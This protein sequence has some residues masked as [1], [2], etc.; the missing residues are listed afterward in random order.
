MTSTPNP[1][2]SSSAPVTVI[3]LAALLVSLAGLLFASAP[4]FAVYSRPSLA[5]ITDTHGLLGEEVPLRGVGGI[6]I[7]GSEN[8][9][10]GV[11]E[12]EDQSVSKFNS[13][14]VF[15]E[16]LTG[17][18]GVGSLAVEDSTDRLYGVGRN[19][20]VAVDNSTDV[21]Y[22]ARSGGALAAFNAKEEPV[23]FAENKKVSYITN[24]ELIGVPCGESGSELCEFTKE[25]ETFAGVVVDPKNG[26]IYVAATIRRAIP[27]IVYEF[28]PSGRFV[29]GFEPGERVP[30]GYLGSGEISRLSGVAVDPTNDDLL[31]GIDEHTASAIDEFTSTGVFR[32]QITGPGPGEFFGQNAFSGG[33]AVSPAGVLYVGDGQRDRVDRWGHGAY[34]PTVVTGGVSGQGVEGV[35][36]A[37]VTLNGVVAGAANNENKDLVLSECE[38]EYVS[39]EAYQKSVSEGKSGFSALTPEE[40]VPCLL[41]SGA[42]PVGSRPE[43]KNYLVHAD[44]SGLESGTVYRYRL[45]AATNEAEDGTGQEGVAESFAAPAMPLVQSA[46]VGEVTSSWADFHAVIDPMGEDTSYQVQYVPASAYEPS[47]ADPYGAGGV[48]PLSPADIGSGDTGVDVGVQAGG[49][50]SGT[51]YHYRVVASNGAG[52]SDGL[53][54]TFSTVPAGLQGLPDG[55]AYE[56][57]TPA[58][59]GDAED[60]FGQI[61]FA[62]GEEENHDDG[63]ASEDGDHFLLVTG[64]SFGPFPA[65]GQGAYVFSRSK[66]GWSF[67]SVAS[68]SL[69]SQTMASLVFDPSDLSMV[70]VEVLATTPQGSQPVD[71]AGP[72][73]GPYVTVAAG[74]LA[75]SI[76]GGTPIKLMGA[77]EDLN[78][79]VVEGTDH[80]LAL[81]EGAQEV[82]E[83]ELDEDSFGLYEWS[84][85]RQCLS[86][87]EVKSEFEGGGLLSKCGA[88]LGMGY[89]QAGGSRGAVSADGSKVFFTVPAVPAVQKGL[90]TGKG[91]WNGGTLNTPQLYMRLNGETTVEVSAPQGVKP[92]HI[93]PAIYVGAAEDGS[94]V[95]FMTKTE[96][97]PDAVALKTS[98][99]ELYEYDTN[100]PEGE[101]LVRVSRG[102]LPSGPV[103]GSVLDVPAISPDGSTVYFNAEGDLTPEAHGGGLYRYETATG[104][105]SYVAPRQGYPDTHSSRVGEKTGGLWYE[106]ETKDKLEPGLDLEAPYDTTRDG[107]FLLFG[108]YRYDAVDGSVVCVMCNPDGSGPI[109]NTSFTRSALESDPA[110]GPVRGISENGE[111]VFFDT[112]E[113]LVPQ[114]TNGKMDVYQ[115]H[116]GTISLISS[117]VDAS[118]SYFLDASP[119]GSNVFFG[120]HAKLVLADTDSEGDLY[121]ARIGGGF[122]PALDVGP[123]EG[124][125]C[126]NPPPV[127][128]DATPAS[129]TFSG[130]G[131]LSVEPPPTAKTKKKTLRC[132][133][134]KKLSHGKCVKAKKAGKTS[135]A[136]RAKK[137]VSSSRD[138]RSN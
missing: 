101:R 42:S 16:Q 92:E 14:N 135:K 123:C 19:E 124:D 118:N 54:G 65:S 27:D 2:R 40:K 73:G 58:N 89:V 76:A 110:A 126:Q 37:R 35:G 53:D 111:Y 69:A 21:H 72:P 81:C 34:Y 105:T 13:A 108:A 128:I 4:A 49:L 79:V 97:T 18:P 46:S 98:E 22:I 114:D 1:H 11:G 94:R 6:A 7:D 41:E 3:A 91:C 32:L 17:L 25:D 88:S 78:N 82:F 136:K 28:E 36:K 103:E 86:L 66:N 62:G 77:S 47:A 107:Q 63:Y 84:S 96:L 87:V 117:G 113:S 64:A 106:S 44:V 134:G 31:V 120:T 29:R 115:W 119:D 130:P 71:P 75:S 51:T 45:V 10:V 33:I 43:E 109:G 100:A 5:P 56:L 15:L 39:E 24:N 95:F 23:E 12:G 127:P 57:V 48:V 133:K 50:V 68:P 20:F 55:R 59:K 122:S 129:L 26:D 99:Q 85:V 138:G 30:K 67:Q 70:G 52:V 60:M 38:F 9:Y 93:Y 125:A 104:T 131:D 61:G 74:P 8:V 90:F 121:D 112:T 83:K 102:D 132:A 137:A 80:K 116:N